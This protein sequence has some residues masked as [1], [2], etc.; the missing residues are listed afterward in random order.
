MRIV[1]GEGNNFV[2]LVVVAVEDLIYCFQ[3]FTYLFLYL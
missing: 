1:N 2:D 3:S